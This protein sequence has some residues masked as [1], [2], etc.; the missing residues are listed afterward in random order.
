MVLNCKQSLGHKRCQ[1][2]MQNNSG[3]VPLLIFFFYPSDVHGVQET[4]PWTPYL[5]STPPGHISFLII[6]FSQFPFL[7][8]ETLCFAHSSVP[9]HKPPL[10]IC[11]QQ[12]LLR[13]EEPSWAVQGA[14]NLP[15]L[16][17]SPYHGSRETR[18][19][20]LP[21]FAL[22]YTNCLQDK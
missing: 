15:V 21:H 20:A 7:A 6:I 13:G 18:Q 8:H 11:S 14:D 4:L 17:F 12:F 5:S 9:V 19:V 3:I 10:T 2:E 1:A 22:H 16:P